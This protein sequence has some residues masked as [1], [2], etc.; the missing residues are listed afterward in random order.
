MRKGME[1][2]KMK[3]AGPH[4]RVEMNVL[5]EEQGVNVLCIYY[6]PPLAISEA[7]KYRCVTKVVG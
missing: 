1:M 3:V 7:K 6:L 4:T 5:P 2:G